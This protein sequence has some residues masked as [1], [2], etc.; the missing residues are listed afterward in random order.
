MTSGSPIK[1]LLRGEL[2]YLHGSSRVGNRPRRKER[3]RRAERRVCRDARRGIK[4]NLTKQ[5]RLLQ[6]LMKT[7]SMAG[8]LDPSLLPTCRGAWLNTRRRSR[9]QRHRSFFFGYLW[10]RSILC[11]TRGHARANRKLASKSFPSHF[12]PRRNWK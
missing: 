8:G 9:A 3:Q 12:F 7:V 6:F 11:V 5:H 4:Q 1:R 10:Q 2:R